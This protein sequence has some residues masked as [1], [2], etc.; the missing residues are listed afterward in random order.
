MQQKP[1]LDRTLGLRAV[2]LFGLAYM[3]PMVVFGTFGVL[4]VVT[5]SAVPAAYIVALIAMIF[6][7]QS[8]G[9][10]A[11]RF[12]HSGSAYVYTSRTF[13]PNLGFMVGWAVL[14]D[15]LF[16]PMVI[17]LIGAAYLA[18]AF[19]LVPKWFWVV[20]YILSSTA[21]NIVGLRTAKKLNFV[22]MAVQILIILAF[23]SLAIYYLYQNDL[24][25]P[26]YQAFA[27]PLMGNDSSTLLVIS[28]AAIACYSFLGFD[29]V[30][31]LAEE[32]HDP[33][34]TIP[35]AILWITVL[36]GVIFIISAYVLQLIFP[37]NT[38]DNV[39][40]AAYSMAEVIGGGAFTVVF[41]AGIILAQFSSGIAAQASGSRLLYVMGRDGVISKKLF[42]QLHGKF[43]TP[44]IAIFF[45]G[46][47]GLIALELDVATS[48][49]FIN[50]GAFLAFFFVNLSVIFH[51]YVNNKDRAERNSIKHL[52]APAIGCVTCLLLL[53][54]LNIDALTLGASWFLIGLIYL[55]YLTKAFTKSAP[56]MK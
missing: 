34:K 36:G 15:Y 39:E 21:I 4:S 31:T 27:A 16:L 1:S 35:R 10:M 20:S 43:H 44:Y 8:Y 54:N 19:P 46:A 45:T 40:T 50:F 29:A 42:A 22:L 18:D 33:R 49:S 53:L 52:I 41:L 9:Q 26:N 30:T 6:T 47:L 17:W 24:F 38:F 14:L 28:G 23:L 3:T 12:P 48:T 25:T 11:S 32:T 55:G 2:V 5:S 37:E 13:G 51:F 7:A 56:Q